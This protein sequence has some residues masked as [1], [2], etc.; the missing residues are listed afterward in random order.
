MFTII[1]RSVCVGIAILV[2]VIVVGIPVGLMIATFFLANSTGHEG[3]AEVGWDL[4]TLAHD[5][6]ITSILVPLLIFALGFIFG[7]RYFSKSKAHN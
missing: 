5:Y 7:F 6:R 4:V 1:L 2:A 3:G